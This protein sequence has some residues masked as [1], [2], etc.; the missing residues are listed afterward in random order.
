MSKLTNRE[1]IVLTISFSLLFL[2]VI[3]STIALIYQ[4]SHSNSFKDLNNS[5]EYL[6]YNSET[7]KNLE[8]I[9]VESQ[10]QIIVKFDSDFDNLVVI[11]L[12]KGT[13]SIIFAQAQI[14]DQ[15][16]SFL[17]VA[18]VLDYSAFMVYFSISLAADSSA[19]LIQLTIQY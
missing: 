14:L 12:A 17:R 7:G 15:T 18:Y 8:G 3:G 13:T 1:K 2:I 16:G 4:S 11:I 6:A 19:E 9:V 5:F 10:N